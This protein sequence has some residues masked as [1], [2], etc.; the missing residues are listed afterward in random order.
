MARGLL[1]KCS[2][3]IVLCQ[4]FSPTKMPRMAPDAPR[5]AIEGNKLLLSLW[6]RHPKSI[7]QWNLIPT[8][9]EFLFRGFAVGAEVHQIVLEFEL[10]RHTVIAIGFP[11][12]PVLVIAILSVLLVKPSDKITFNVIFV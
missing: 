4:A 1:T 8:V 6:C 11:D 2:Q 5:M 12:L 3:K 9:M 7:R 10:D